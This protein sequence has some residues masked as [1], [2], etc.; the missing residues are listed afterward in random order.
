MSWKSI[1]LYLNSSVPFLSRAAV[2]FQKT[3]VS[4]SVLLLLDIWVIFG[5][6]ALT[7]L[8]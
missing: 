5:F 8:L 7:L 1:Q 3:H 6:F 4:L 2:V